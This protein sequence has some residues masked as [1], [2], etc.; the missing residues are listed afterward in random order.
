[1]H[2]NSWGCMC[3]TWLYIWTCAVSLFKNLSQTSVWRS[4][5]V[6]RIMFSV[7]FIHGVKFLKNPCFWGYTYLKKCSCQGFQS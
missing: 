2:L 5:S 6:I 7:L 3:S 1:M 4:L